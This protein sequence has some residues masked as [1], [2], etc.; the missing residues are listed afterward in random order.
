MAVLVTG[1]AGFIGFHVARALLQRGEAVVGIDNV[2]SYY[3]P[4]L[5]RDRL[6]ILA[7]EPAFSFFERDIADPQAFVDIQ[8]AQA[9]NPISGVIHLAAQAGVRHSYEHPEEF[10]PSNL[11]GFYNAIAFAANQR[12]GHFVYAS[13]S[14]V[15]G[16]G[17]HYPSHEAMAAN[18]PLSLYAATKK[19]NEAMAHALAHIHGMPT[20]GLRFFTVYGPWG[21]PDMSFFRFAQAILAGAPI[22][23][24]NNGLMTRDFTYI[25]DIVAGVLAAFDCPP[26]VDANWE[27]APTSATSGVAP[28]RIFNIGSGRPVDLETYVGAFET[29]IGRTAIRRNVPMHPGEALDTYADPSALQAW[30][31]AAPQTSLQDGVSNFVAWYRDYYSV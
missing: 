31:G 19:S 25:D 30:V 3:D 14:S 26:T 18:H 6:A 13:T 17:P 5:K 10:V 12:V 1:V 7:A 23:L 20:T 27:Q 22:D 2:N 4:R 21:R 15:Y 8:T 16:P 28:Y 24:H 9:S 29:A 11:V